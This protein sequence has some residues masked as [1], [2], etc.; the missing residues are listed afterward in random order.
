MKIYVK[1]K[2]N[3]KLCLVWFKDKDYYCQITNPKWYG[4]WLNV[5][6][7]VLEYKVDSVNYVVVELEWFW[8]TQGH[9]IL[10]KIYTFF[11]SI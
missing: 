5:N 4:E 1:Q 6:R 2:Y 9:K 7:V 10:E 11:K 8:I 3:D